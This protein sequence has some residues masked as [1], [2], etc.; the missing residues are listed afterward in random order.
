MVSTIQSSK[1]VFLEIG[2]FMF[3]MACVLH[4]ILTNMEAVVAGA[5]RRHPGFALSIHSPHCERMAFLH[6]VCAMAE[7]AAGGAGSDEGCVAAVLGDTLRRVCVLGGLAG[8]RR[9]LGSVYAGSVTRFLGGFRGFVARTL[10]MVD[11]GPGAESGGMAVTRDG[12]ALLVTCKS[13]D[14]LYVIDVATGE[15]LRKIGCRGTGPLQFQIPHR[16]CIADDDC[17]FVADFGNNRIQVLTRRLDFH[18][19]VGVR[20]LNEPVG[21]CVKGDVVAVSEI[22]SHRITV[23]CRVDGALIRRFGSFGNSESQLGSP[24][25]LCFVGRTWQLAVVDMFKNRVA[26]FTLEGEFL[27]SILYHQHTTLYDVASSSAGELVVVDAT[28]ERGCVWSSGGELLHSMVS[29]KNNFARVAIHG[30]TV[31][32][33]TLDGCTTVFK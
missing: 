3:A 22:K 17:V 7:G 21:V 18:G 23:F 1:S 11:W 13:T 2:A 29:C 20:Q 10:R 9:S 32:A 33:Q 15:T 19:F 8:L 25:G 31:F 12:A 24:V 4:I 6:A 27:H 26:K 14:C 5:H 16:V 30:A 28:Y